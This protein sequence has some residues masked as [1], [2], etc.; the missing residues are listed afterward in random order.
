MKIREK[1]KRLNFQHHIGLIVEPMSFIHTQI[2][3]YMST[4]THKW[5][6]KKKSHSDLL[7]TRVP[8]NLTLL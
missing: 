6:R 7:S 5:E 3:T 1:K 2:H 4:Y 8:P